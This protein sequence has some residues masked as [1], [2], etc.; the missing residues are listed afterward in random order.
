L[1]LLP[2]IT[3]GDGLNLRWLLGARDH[4]LPPAAHEWL[5]AKDASAPLRIALA[6]LTEVA[7]LS[8]L[9]SLALPDVD[10]R[11]WAHALHGHTGGNPLFI[12]ETLLALLQPGAALARTG[13][14]LPA[15]ANVGQLIETRLNRLGA[16]ALSLARVA[17]LAGKNFS[18]ELAGHVLGKH[19]LDLSDPWNELVEAHVIR[20]NHFAHDLMLEATQRSMPSTLA[21]S[22]HQ[23]IAEY[24]DRLGTAA[25]DAAF[26]W[27]AAR[28]WQRAGAAWQR[29]AQ[30]ALDLSRRA[31][32]LVLLRRAAE[33]VQ[34][35]PQPDDKERFDIELRS[36]RAALL[37]DRADQSRAFAQAALALAH[38]AAARASALAVLAEAAEFMGEGE[39]ALEHAAQGLSLAVEIGAPPAEDLKHFVR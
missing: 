24:L 7:V 26:H 15:P 10:A 34:N 4:E 28:E 12:L 18:V 20:D 3:R 2:G 23:S 38:D 22:L 37:I 27:Q 8:L 14:A 32:E 21:R 16:V 31:E 35:V 5:A 1:D 29:A 9:E 25:I 19:R 6:P 36:A 33:C 11:A 17:A 30:Q 39:Q 13:K